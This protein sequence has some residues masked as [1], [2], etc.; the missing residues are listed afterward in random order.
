[1]GGAR[2]RDFRRRRGEYKQWMVAN[3][4]AILESALTRSDDQASN[5]GDSVDADAESNASHD[6]SLDRTRRDA[7]NAFVAWK[8][9]NNIDEPGSG[10]G[11]DALAARRA[12]HG[13]DASDS[14]EGTSDTSADPAFADASERVDPKEVEEGRRRGRRAEDLELS[15]PDDEKK[16]ATFEAW[17]RRVERENG[18]A[19]ERVNDDDKPIVSNDD[20]TPI[21]SNDDDTP[22]V[23][24][25][26]RARTPSRRGARWRIRA[27]GGRRGDARVDRIPM[28]R[29]RR[30]DP[31]RRVGVGVARSI[32][33]V[34]ARVG[35]PPGQ[36]R[37]QGDA[38]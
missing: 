33:G 34:R 8:R 31:R 13:D 7:K 14:L 17:K 21:V 24:K 23:S 26:G 11:A 37:V 2:A 35:F 22:I 36:A 19:T 28:G 5:T 20:D 25:D 32:R 12:I 10:P 4:K 6:A 1:M 18:V 15:S 3:G 27:T 29:R 38:R 16:L 9:A 30:R